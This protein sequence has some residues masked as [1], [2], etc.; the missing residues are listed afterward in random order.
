MRDCFHLL[1]GVADP[2]RDD[3][4][5]KRVS[6]GFETESAWRKMIGK[7]VVHDVAPR[8]PAAKRA[9]AAFHQ[10]T[11]CPSGSKIGPGDINRRLSFAGAVTLKPP[12]GGVIC[13][14]SF[15][16]DLRSTGRPASAAREVMDAGSRSASCSAQ[17]GAVM[18]RAMKSGSFE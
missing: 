12:K 15:R 8:K 5:A 1:L 16:S 3:C 2:A 13:C 17:P 9:R 10:S 18:A 14:R 6:T 11:P 7:S 4:A